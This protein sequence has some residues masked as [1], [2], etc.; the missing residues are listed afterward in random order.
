M[1][2]SEKRLWKALRALGLHI[3]RQAPIGRYVADFAHHGARLIV[4]VDGAWHDL[5]EAQLHDEERDAWLLEQG[6]RV[7]RIRSREAF[8]Y[9]YDIAA[10]VAAEI[11]RSPPSPALPPSRGKGARSQ[12][13]GGHRVLDLG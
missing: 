12:K 4:E 9:A 13:S 7:L 5:P 1:T 3:R 6:Y 8:D 2:A 10:R 11:Q